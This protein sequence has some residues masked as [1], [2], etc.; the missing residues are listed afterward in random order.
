MPIFN[1][2]LNWVVDHAPEIQQFV[3]DAISFIQKGIQDLMPIIKGL[4][5]I[6][7]GV[8]NIIKPLWENI[9]KPILMGIIEFLGGVFTG[10]WEQV[11]SG[12]ANI[13]KGIFESLVETVKAPING[14][15]TLLNLAIDGLNTIKV[16]DW[17]P[18][19]GGKGINIQ[20]ITMLAKGGDIVSSGTVLVGEKGPELLNLPTGARVTPLSGQNSTDNEGRLVEILLAILEK[21]REMDID[22]TIPVNLMGDQYDMI[23]V[24][25]AQRYAYKT[26]GR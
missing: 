4:A 16:P 23:S 17:V 6:V 26:G 7:E 9:L 18:G 11:F 1:D 13:V 10:N 20:H 12:L 21:L 22:I 2:L 14:I 3:S 19:V 5:P 24:S 15:I 8:F 25:A